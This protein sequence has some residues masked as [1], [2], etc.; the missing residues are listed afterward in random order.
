VSA[1]PPQPPQPVALVVNP[2]NTLTDVKLAMLR[3]VVMG[4]QS[5]WGNR[6]SVGL[7][8]PEPGT[9]EREAVLRTVAEMTGP[10]FKQ[11]WLAKVFRGEAPGE[12][13]NELQ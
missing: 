4:E 11:H 2:Q 9:R 3:K 7:V 13:G 6:L 12:E 8:L 1:Q 10:Q 5:V